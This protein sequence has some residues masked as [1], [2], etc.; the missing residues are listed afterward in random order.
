[1]S[2]YRDLNVRVKHAEA[3]KRPLKFYC[4]GNIFWRRQRFW[5][6]L[7]QSFQLLPRGTIEGAEHKKKLC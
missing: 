3:T 7:G 5:G 6:E 2:D 4:G 1:M